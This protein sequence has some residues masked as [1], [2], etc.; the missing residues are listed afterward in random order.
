MPSFSLYLKHWIS[1][2]G[3]KPVFC[4]SLTH[5][6]RLL[7]PFTSCCKR[8]LLSRTFPGQPFRLWCLITLYL[9]PF[10]LPFMILPKGILWTSAYSSLHCL[11]Q[12]S[13][14]DVWHRVTCR[15]NLNSCNTPKH[16]PG[17]PCAPYGGG[18]FMPGNETACRWGAVMVQHPWT[19]SQVT[20]PLHS[21]P[22]RS[23]LCDHP[24]PPEGH[25][26]TWVHSPTSSRS[27]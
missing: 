22:P 11:V 26:S 9:S 25:V 5:P 24:S 7:S 21:R 8:P 20:S 13:M 12:H 15:Q 18:S 23:N 2:G 19:G 1:P 14:H 6:G 4:C 16:C 10:S 17:P 3:E 27:K